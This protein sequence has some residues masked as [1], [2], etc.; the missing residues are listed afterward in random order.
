MLTHHGLE[1]LATTVDGIGPRI[2][3]LYSVNPDDGSITDS[4][5]VSRAHALGLVV[6]PYTLRRDAPAPGFEDFDALLRFLSDDVGIDGV[7]TDFPD[8]VAGS[9]GPAG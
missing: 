8:L 7:F 1:T 6:H 3:D 2:E 9:H 5:L 4:G